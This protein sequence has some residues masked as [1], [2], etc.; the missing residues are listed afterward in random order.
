MMVVILVM[1]C[2]FYTM[3][4]LNNAMDPNIRNLPVLSL[5][6]PPRSSYGYQ[7]FYSSFSNIRPL[8]NPN[9]LNVSIV[10][11]LQISNS[12]IYHKSYTGMFVWYGKIPT[13]WGISNIPLPHC[14][15]RLLQFW[16]K[17]IPNTNQLIIFIGFIM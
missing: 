12:N 13:F 5:T 3:V 9:P 4:D 16:I 15:I 17:P 8:F 2:T 7:Y 1:V 6:Y 14:K 10:L 11:F